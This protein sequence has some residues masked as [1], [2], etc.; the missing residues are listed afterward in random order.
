MNFDL[1]KFVVPSE[2]QYKKSKSTDR[3]IERAL[4][5][6]VRLILGSECVLQ[7]RAQSHSRARR[8]P[9]C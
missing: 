3:G 1:E 8:K 6:P 5:C 9:R 7:G 4:M 2:A